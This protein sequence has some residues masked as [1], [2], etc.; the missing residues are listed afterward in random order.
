MR[1]SLAEGC[2][3]RS[4]SRTHRPQ[5][6][7]LLL[8]VPGRIGP[9]K[10]N[11]TILERDHAMVGDGHAMGVAA[12]ILHV[13]RRAATS[14]TSLSSMLVLWLHNPARAF[15]NLSQLDRKDHEIPLL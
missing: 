7:E 10:G 3:A 8:M 15:Y 13:C 12:E 14:L 11:P 2:A 9:A 4:A 5:G 6:P 1:R